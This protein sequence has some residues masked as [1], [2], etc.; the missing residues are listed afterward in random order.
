MFSRWKIERKGR[1]IEEKSYGFHVCL[2][3]LNFYFNSNIVFYFHPLCQT[4]HKDKLM[5]YFDKHFD[6]TCVR[7]F[8]YCALIM[9]D[10]LSWNC[11][12]LFS[13]F[14]IYELFD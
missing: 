10:I 6:L 5:Y 12:L 3:P 13:L 1:E 8:K 7:H 2:T 14:S 11:G 4:E 9:H